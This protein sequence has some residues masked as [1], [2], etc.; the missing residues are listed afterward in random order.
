MGFSEQLLTLFSDIPIKGSEIREKLKLQTKPQDSSINEPSMQTSTAKT[1]KEEPSKVS[2]SDDKI[3]DFGEPAPNLQH[4]DLELGLDDLVKVEKPLDLKMNL[5]PTKKKVEKIPTS[6]SKEGEFL[7]IV[8]NKAA[9]SKIAETKTSEDYHKDISGKLLDMKLQPTKLQN[10]D[11]LPSELRKVEKEVEPDKT[12]EERDE[13]EFTPVGTKSKETILQERKLEVSDKEQTSTQEHQATSLEK[14]KGRPKLKTMP[15]KETFDTC[16][17]EPKKADAI[18]HDSDLEDVINDAKIL[19]KKIP[20]LTNE[21]RR[22]KFAE[23]VESK[24]PQLK[25]V[26]AFPE[27]QFS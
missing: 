16:S 9:A 15:D 3:M 5:K 12:L 20:R 14:S 21:K 8:K 18:L 24:L 7:E 27:K 1:N 10:Y 17:T 13:K 25:A 11:K 22:S 2:I 26:S 23:H 19:V 6:V 4:F